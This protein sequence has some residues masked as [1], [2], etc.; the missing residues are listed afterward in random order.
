MSHKFGVQ[1]SPLS[2]R[3]LVGRVNANQT[4]FTSK[5]EHTG[6]VL[7]AVAQYVQHALDSDGFVE[8]GGLR[9]DIKVTPVDD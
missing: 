8:V 5:E 3:I 4:A 1:Y 7:H 9:M 6:E 2:E